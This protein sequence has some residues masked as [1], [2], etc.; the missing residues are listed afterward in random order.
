MKFYS[1]LLIFLIGCSVFSQAEDTFEK[2]NSAYADD[3]FEEATKLYNQVLD[4]G[5][6]SSEL[7]FNLGNAYF[8]QNDLANAIYHYEKALQ[9]NRGDEEIKENLEI[10]NTQTIDKIEAAP[11]SN[12]DSLLFKIT[13]M[14][15]LE[16]WAWLSI[17]FSVLFGLFIVLYFRVSSAK[18]KRNNFSI[19]M[20]FLVL[21]IA[22]LLLGRFQNQFQE[23][24]SFAIIFEN[25]LPVYAEP[26]PR[27]DV[28]FELNEGTKV[29]LGTT[30]RDYTEIELSDG[31]EGW[32]KSS[33]F[34]RL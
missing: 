10:A 11:E 24:Q 14:M 34:K 9:Y 16:S 26:N 3:Q 30:F 7:Y 33:S 17:G 5:L 27:S 18:G 15:S 32:V 20:L 19:A 29:N 23:K 1:Q 6:V 28:N 22:S 8:K 13:H 25:Q 31:S 21:A 2:A 4:E 12:I